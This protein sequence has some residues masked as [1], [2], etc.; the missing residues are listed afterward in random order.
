MLVWSTIEKLFSAQAGLG[1]FIKMASSGQS[2]YPPVGGAAGSISCRS[3][4]PRNHMVGG[5]NSTIPSVMVR[6]LHSGASATS[7]S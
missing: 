4:L 6:W 2:T 3:G 7:Y 5:I 1:V